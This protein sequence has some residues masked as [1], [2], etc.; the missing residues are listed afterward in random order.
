M[1]PARTIARSICTPTRRAPMA[2]SSPRA[3]VRAAF[4]AGVRTFALTDHDTLAGY[5]E[6][7]AS[8]ASCP[9]D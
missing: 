8:G 5:R 1:R 2:C 6:V 4:D 9:T 3:L 7:V